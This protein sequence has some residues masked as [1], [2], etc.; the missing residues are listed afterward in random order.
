[1]IPSPTPDKIHAIC[2]LGV[3]SIHNITKLCILPMSIEQPAF[4]SRLYSL[5]D[6]SLLKYFVLACSLTRPR[7]GFFPRPWNKEGV[8]FPLRAPLYFQYTKRQAE[9]GLTG[10]FIESGMFSA[11]SF[12]TRFIGNGGVGRWGNANCTFILGP[13]VY[14]RGSQSRGQGELV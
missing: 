11:L 10:P 7:S 4:S 9:G 2:T 6:F 8:K 12:D 3:K 5:S 13:N 14:N 1:M